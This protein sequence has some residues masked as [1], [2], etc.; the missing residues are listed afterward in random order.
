MIEL[1]VHGSETNKFH[2]PKYCNMAMPKWIIESIWRVRSWNDSMLSMPTCVRTQ[3]AS[4]VTLN[5]C[6]STSTYFPHCSCIFVV[7]S[8]SAYVSVSGTVCICICCCTFENIQRPLE[9]FTLRKTV[10]RITLVISIHSDWKWS[11][12]VLVI[13]VWMSQLL[14]QIPPRGEPIKLFE[15][16]EFSICFSKK[17]NKLQSWNLKSNICNSFLSPF[18][19][20]SNFAKDWKWWCCL[21]PQKKLCWDHKIFVA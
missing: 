21:L 19:G 12:C 13:V 10:C 1:N 3:R 14:G 11:A 9:L 8:V 7:Q 5:R 20:S 2:I 6:S 4:S 18:L 15:S 16:L 17:P